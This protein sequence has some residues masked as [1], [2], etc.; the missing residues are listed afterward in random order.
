MS[1]KMGVVEGY[2]AIRIGVYWVGVIKG[3]IFTKYK[4]RSADRAL[5]DCRLLMKN[6]N[7]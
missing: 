3:D 4:R 6:K 7:L 5:S 1:R 2:C